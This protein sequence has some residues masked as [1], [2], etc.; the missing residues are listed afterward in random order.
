MKIT[1]TF[2]A[3]TAA[4]AALAAMPAAAQVNGIATSSPEAAIA[5]AAART[6]GY[7]AISQTYATQIQQINT[8]RQQARDLQVSLDTNGDGQLTQAEAQAN[9]NVQTQLQGLQQQIDTAGRPA[10]IAQIYVIEQI[11]QRYEAAQQQVIQ[12]K[13]IQMMLTP[14]AFQYAPQGVDVTQDI[15][16]ALNTLMPTVNTAPPANYQPTRGAV[17]AHQAIQQLLLVAA[18]QQQA[19]AQAQ[20]PEQQAPSGR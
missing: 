7:G 2:F 6:Q 15:V 1:R 5:S 19:Q 8:L 10:Q 4:A 11:V 14:E 20:Q 16:T 3:L 12:Q 17:E 18:E 9:P 13:G